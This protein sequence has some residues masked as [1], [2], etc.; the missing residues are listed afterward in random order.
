[1]ALFDE[2]PAD[3][4]HFALEHEGEQNVLRFLPAPPFADVRLFMRG[5]L[6][7]GTEG[8]AAAI[9][10]RLVPLLGP[11]G[12]LMAPRQVHGVR[13]LDSALEDTL[14]ARLEGDGIL[15]TEP[16]I[17]VSLRFADCAP[18]LVIPCEE[19]ARG[20]PWVLMLHSGY[21][22]TVQNIAR[23]GLEKVARTFGSGAVA[24]ALAWVGPCIGG[25]SY[26]RTLEE[27]TER[28][29][30]IFH[31]DNVR[32]ADGH[33]YFDIAGELR[34]QLMD[35]GI[36]PERIFLSRMDTASRRETCY[37]YRGGDRADRMFL[38][39]RLT[40]LP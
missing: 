25:N 9:R 20:R 26:P 22:G 29:L 18:L 11:E 3:A 23:A 34:R 14:P 38:H 5:P 40:P 4:E 39:A 35:C 6:L 31:P 17:E 12:P 10:A 13:V 32:E 27:W 7:E 8:A 30:A 15:L 24:S 28:G 36:G 37:S 21:K 1:M 33:Y 19:Q 16:G 2:R